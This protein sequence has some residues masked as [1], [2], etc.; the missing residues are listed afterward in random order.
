MGSFGDW[1]AVFLGAVLLGAPLALTGCSR[2]NPVKIVLTTGFAGDELFRLEDT[3]CTRQEFMVYLT[4]EQ[5]RYEAVY[6]PDLWE[7]EAEGE[8]LEERLKDKALAE[9]SQVKAMTLL[10]ELRGITLSEQEEKKVQEAVARYYESME[11]AERTALDVD[12]ACLEGMYRDYALADK[13]YREIIRDI[14]PEISDDE[15]R[16]ITVQHVTISTVRENGDGTV[17]S[18]SEAEKEKCYQ[19]AR[20]VQAEA[21]AGASFESL[22]E[23]YS[24]EPQGTLSFGK[25]EM[26]PSFEEAAFNLGNGEISG[27]VETSRGYEIIKCIS[28]FN[29]EET[30]RNKEKIVE[31]RKAEVFGQ[32]Y[33]AFVDSLA[34]NLNEPMWE[35]I[36]LIREE[37][38][39]TDD[40]FRIYREYFPSC[41]DSVG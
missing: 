17:T 21:A 41:E 27:V 3:A 37:G 19:T 28:T 5:N 20:Q 14:N 10:A 36:T 8:S 35:S 30:D 9:I 1:A 38:V 26:E 23:K 32:E 11:D 31:Q 25:G 33:D 40:F 2:E 39:D 7:H 16:T 6:G 4:N 22:M 29:R 12:A 15:A 34:R 13:V 24:D 18:L